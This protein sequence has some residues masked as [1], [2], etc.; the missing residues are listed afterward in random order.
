[1]FSCFIWL[2][3]VI[4]EIQLLIFFTTAVCLLVT[5]VC[6]GVLFC[7]VC[8]VVGCWLC[9]CVCCVVGCVVVLCML[10]CV[11]KGFRN[12][13]KKHQDF[14]TLTRKLQNEELQRKH[15]IYCR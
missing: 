11:L 15:C 4:Y 12:V 14:G 6:F 10:C 7:C 8:C 13:L 1:M 2:F 5:V 3:I 9:C